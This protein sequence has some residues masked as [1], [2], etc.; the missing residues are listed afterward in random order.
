MLV[1]LFIKY[2]D[3]TKAACLK[4]A[5]F[6]SA[7]AV[8]FYCIK[9]FEDLFSLALYWSIQIL[10]CITYLTTHLSSAKAV[11]RIYLY[12]SANKCLTIKNLIN[13]YFNIIFN[14]IGL[15]T[16]T[17]LSV[18]RKSKHYSFKTL[19]NRISF[20]YNSSYRVNKL[21]ITQ[22]T[23]FTQRIPWTLRLCRQKNSFQHSTASAEV[24]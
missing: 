8:L 12:I 11:S 24:T 14:K 5:I 21:A 20:L 9:L 2:S 19:G 15:L 22:H 18:N 7:S 23:L 13:T 1:H 4:T 16:S 17:V 10:P 3:L 6:V